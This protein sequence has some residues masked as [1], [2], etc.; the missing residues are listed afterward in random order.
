MRF[1]SDGRAGKERIAWP[2]RRSKTGRDYAGV[3]SDMR[4]RPSQHKNPS[5]NPVL[6]HAGIQFGHRLRSMA[7][8]EHT[9]VL[10]LAKIS[11]VARFPSVTSAADVDELV[12]VKASKFIKVQHVSTSEPQ[13]FQQEAAK[14]TRGQQSSIS[15]G[16]WFGTRRPVVQIRSAGRSSSTIEAFRETKRN[17]L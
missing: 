6:V 13:R 14:N 11:A 16:I 9:Y 10:S 5:E 7:H 12:P 2:A 17:T 3:A 15:L 4:T 1:R 8:P